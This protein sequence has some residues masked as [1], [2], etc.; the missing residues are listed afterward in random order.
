MNSSVQKVCTSLDDLAA[1][2]LK[3]HSGDATL[4]ETW[5]WSLPALNRHD[6]ANILTSISSRLEKANI[7]VLDEEIEDGIEEIPKRINV[8]KSQTLQYI[9]NGNGNHASAAY[10]SLVEWINITLSPL[11]EWEVL[12]DNKALPN[13]LAKR[14]RGIQADLNSI[15]P[16]KEVL[17]KQIR[18]IKEAVEAAESLPADLETLKSAR[19]QVSSLSTQS[20]ESY[21]KIDTFLKDSEARYKNIADKKE[22]ADKLV[23]Q[24]EIAYRITTTKGLAAAFDLRAEKLANTMWA[25]VGG[26]A[27]ALITGGFVGASRFQALV[28][29]LQASNPHWGVIWMD[30]GLSLVSLAGPVWFAWIATKQINQRFRLS[31]DYAFKASVAKAYE[32]YRKEAA[33]IDETFEA[34][35]FSSAL[36]RLEEAPLRLVEDEYHGSPWHELFSSPAFQKAL[37]TVPDLK[38]KFISIA[39]EEIN[40]ITSKS[41][42]PDV[43]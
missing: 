11:F 33:R 17:E 37:D 1:S 7:S 28:Q 23:E 9:F 40:N 18:L 16:D 30:L 29:A 39:K 2:I 8:F 13:Q 32:G 22:E 35:L 5:G 3:S 27:T 43:E 26:L 36:S 38:D 31:E 42:A 4:A 24:C 14:L 41:K 20:A 12:Q 25:W 15:T 21:G 10:F 6:L 19:T 34:R